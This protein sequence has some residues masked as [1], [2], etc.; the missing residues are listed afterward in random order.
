MVN[1]VDALD[2][3]I[4]AQAAAL[5]DENPQTMVAVFESATGAYLYA[6]PSHAGLVGYEPPELAGKTLTA[7]VHPDDL[8]HTR[9]AFMDAVLHGKSIE[10]GVRLVHKDGRPVR[11]RAAAKHVVTGAGRD[12]MLG[13]AT[14][15]GDEPSAA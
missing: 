12:L 4:V 9:L 8:E 11:V 7:L 15:V 5:A 1:T 10:I 13:Q 3:D 6:S 2:A 14:P